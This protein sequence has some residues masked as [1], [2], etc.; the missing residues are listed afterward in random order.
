MEFMLRYACVVLKFG[1]FIGVE[2]KDLWAL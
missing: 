2:P 1:N